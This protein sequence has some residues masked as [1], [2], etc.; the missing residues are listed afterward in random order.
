MVLRLR[1]TTKTDMDNFQ[2]IQGQ[3]LSGSKDDE[4]VMK[5]GHQKHR[6]PALMEP[7]LR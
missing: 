7:E 4:T 5:I 1:Y 2:T 3:I 6:L